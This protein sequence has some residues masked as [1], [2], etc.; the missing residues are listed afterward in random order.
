MKKSV[1]ESKKGKTFSKS[2]N[3]NKALYNKIDLIK[4]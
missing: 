4:N 1:K 2:K 3:Q